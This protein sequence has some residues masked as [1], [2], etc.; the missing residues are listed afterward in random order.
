M[1][2]ANYNRRFQAKKQTLSRKLAQKLVYFKLGSVHYAI[3]IERVLRVLKEFTP[4]A[5]LSSGQSLV[6]SVE[7]IITLI[8]LSQLFFGTSQSADFHYLIV[9]ILASKEQLGIPIPEMP[10]ILEVAEDRFGDIPQAY[11]QGGLH[12]AAEKLIHTPDG[13]EVFYLNPDLLI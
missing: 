9:C 12:T 1:T 6:R 4:Y 5:A 2:H 13:I 10:K 3:A 8:D 11:R 7:G